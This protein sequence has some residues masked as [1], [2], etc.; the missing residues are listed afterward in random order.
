MADD[1]DAATTYDAGEA[2]VGGEEAS[3]IS[4][5]AVEA[6]SHRQRLHQF[7]SDETRPADGGGMAMAGGVG[8][9]AASS[10]GNFHARAQRGWCAVIPNNSLLERSSSLNT[11]PSISQG[12]SARLFVQ[13]L[14]W[15][16]IASVTVSTVSPSHT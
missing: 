1:G 4:V 13:Y 5:R 6:A 7:L 10:G 8:G 12:S 14:V 2:P 16:I 15:E 9:G 3:C 11:T